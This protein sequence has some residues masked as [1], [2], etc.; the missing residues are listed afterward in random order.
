MY[1]YYFSS[2]STDSPDLQ[3]VVTF[4]SFFIL[5]NTLI[6][7]SIMITME[8]VKAIQIF[9]INKDKLLCEEPE[10]KVNVISMKL[11]EDLGAVSYIFSDKTGTLTKNEMRFKACSIF[12][13]LFS[14]SILNDDKKGNPENSKDK[15]K[16]VF[17]TNFDKNIII[18]SFL[19]DEPLNCQIGFKVDEN[20]NKDKIEE[21]IKTISTLPFESFKDVITEF[22]LNIALNHNVLTEENSGKFEYQGSNPDEVA[23]VTSAAEVNIKFLER[24]GNIVKVKILDK[25]REF[26]ILQKFEFSSERMRSSVIVK[27]DNGL[28]KLY[29]KGADSVLLKKIDKFSENYL[30]NSTKNHIDEFAKEGLRTL[31]Y[32]IK[33]LSPNDYYSWERNFTEIKFKAINDKTLI[34]EMENEISKLEGE[35][36][37]LGCTGL[38]DKLQ[39]SVKSVL[40]EF[41]DAGINL[42]MLTGDKLD[43]AE[44]IGYSC[45]IFN[46]DSEVFKLRSNN[47][48]QEVK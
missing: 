31:C 21:N 2:D 35:M 40:K 36:L 43:T 34:P 18:Q 39:D 1:L 32:S 9:N 16:Q 11:H 15:E 17:S 47:N 10:E 7:I 45:K 26:E 14:E 48:I 33:Y 4:S 13:R 46:D 30:L 25:I 19:S 42:W 20:N 27:D 23:L 6:P 12:T 22:F 29:M 3:G 28:I 41:M 5:F 8:F 38:E 24:I 44:T 37:L